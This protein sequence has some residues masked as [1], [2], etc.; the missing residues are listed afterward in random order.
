VGTHVTSGGA[1][2]SELAAGHAAP[3]PLLPTDA[4][5]TPTMPTHPDD[6]WR[7]AHGTPIPHEC[8][9]EQVAVDTILGAA[10][11]RLHQQ[12]QV[13]DRA[14]TRLIVLFDDDDTLVHIRPHLVRVLSTP[15]SA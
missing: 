6:P 14:T 10:P 2:G 5:V 4:E 9:I 8:R 3:Y 12:A 11:S 1:P 15:D 13:I 7:D